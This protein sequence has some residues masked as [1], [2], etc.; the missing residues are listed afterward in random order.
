M[1]NA[2]SD[3]VHAA[4]QYCTQ[5]WFTQISSV[6]PHC[7]LVVQARP[8]GEACSASLMHLEYVASHF[9][10]H[11]VA[12][13]WSSLYFFFPF[14]STIFTSGVHFARH[15]VSLRWQLYNLKSLF[16]EAGVTFASQKI[17]KNKGRIARTAINNL[18]YVI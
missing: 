16:A 8:A 6:P 13:V 17:D 14:S 9:F 7:W 1:E 11:S 4:D 10:L 15:E 12:L 3:V 18:Q 5:R 2:T